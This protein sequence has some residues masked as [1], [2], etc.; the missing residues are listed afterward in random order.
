MEAL[1]RMV[2]PEIDLFRKRVSLMIEHHLPMDEGEIAQILAILYQQP[3]V[4]IV[5]Y[6]SRIQPNEIYVVTKDGKSWRITRP[7]HLVRLKFQYRL[8]A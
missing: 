3:W 1:V 5:Q 2:E 7:L 6:P 4:Q 8:V